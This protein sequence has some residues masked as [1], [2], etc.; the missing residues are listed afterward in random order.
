M[1]PI[2]NSYYYVSE[3]F[4]K[5]LFISSLPWSPVLVEECKRVGQ[6]LIKLFLL[7]GEIWLW[8]NFLTLF[9][10]TLDTIGVPVVSLGH[11]ANEYNDPWWIICFWIGC[12]CEQIVTCGKPWLWASLSVVPY[13]WACPYWAPQQRWLRNYYSVLTRNTHFRNLGFISPNSCLPSH[14]FSFFFM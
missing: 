14:V 2:Q 11:V 12:N 8:V 4:H 10:W 5:K 13:N 3:P 6:E 9:G 7:Q 1:S